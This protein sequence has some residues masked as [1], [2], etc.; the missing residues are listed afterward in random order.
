M[1]S[2]QHNTN[3]NRRSLIDRSNSIDK[4]KSKNSVNNSNDEKKIA[5]VTPDVK[6]KKHK[7]KIMSPDGKTFVD[8]SSYNKY[9][10]KTF[11]TFNDK[12]DLKGDQMLIK[13]PEEVNNVPFDIANIENCEM[14]VLG[15]TSQVQ[16]DNV[17][18]S[19]LFIGPV[20]GTAFVRNCKDVNLTIACRQLRTL[21]CE[22]C[23]LNYMRQRIL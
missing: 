19:K 12:K 13:Y 5:V 3:T 20:D 2:T 14:A 22:N 17:N 8:Q 21:G 23:T 1:Q 18:N 10:M 4:S 7:Q 16:I 11:Y 6:S 15:L 9:M